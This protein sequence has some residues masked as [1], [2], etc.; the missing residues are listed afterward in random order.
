MVFEGQILILLIVWLLI[1][2]GW[3]IY[4]EV[5]FRRFLSKSKKGDIRR[6]LE[7]LLKNISRQ[8]SD[9]VKVGEIL[10]QIKKRDLRH[11]Q[12]VGLIRFNPFRDVGG[13]QSFTLSLL[14]EED[15]GIVLT[16]LHSRD[17]TRLYIKDVLRGK[18]KSEL[19]KEE[20]N[21]IEAARK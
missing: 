21:A 7:D 18:G 4:R 10:E 17:T 8:D 11:I 2:T 3:I 16:G 9:L 12:K 13:N 1:V 20:K 19:S 5:N 6:I 15:S 14:N